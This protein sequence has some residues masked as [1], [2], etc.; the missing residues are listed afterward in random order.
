MWK[1]KNGIPAAATTPISMP[2]LVVTQT[3]TLPVITTI[4]T[5]CSDG[6]DGFNSKTTF[7][8]D[9]AKLAL[10]VAPYTF[11]GP[12]QVVPNSTNTVTYFVTGVAATDNRH[13]FNFK[14][15]TK[16]TIVSQDATSCTVQWN[17]GE[18]QTGSV[19]VTAKNNCHKGESSM[20]TI[21]V[22]SNY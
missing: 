11:N 22:S 12:T 1:N 10:E 9:F 3:S 15:S 2:R 16:G 7:T 20:R 8:N 17:L 14:V 13:S 6:S 4:T 19:T 18:E 5:P 21:K